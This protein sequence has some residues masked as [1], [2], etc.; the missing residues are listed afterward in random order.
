[1]D[2]AKDIFFMQQSV[3]VQARGQQGVRREDLVK[4]LGLEGSIWS[5]WGPSLAPLWLQA[6]VSCLWLRFGMV[7]GC[8]NIDFDQCSSSETA[9]LVRNWLGFG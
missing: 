3:K 8:K 9:K 5:V 2:K 7:G 1:M 4:N 6:V